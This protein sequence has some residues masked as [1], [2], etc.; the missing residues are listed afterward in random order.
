MRIFS[1]DEALLKLI[2]SFNV[3]EGEIR[4]LQDLLE[5]NHVNKR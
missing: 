3:G 4:V 2:V 1:N 5:T